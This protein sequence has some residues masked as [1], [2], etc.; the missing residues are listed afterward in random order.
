[1]PPT[2]D[3][4]GAAVV[5]RGYDA[6]AEA[7]ISRHNQRMSRLEQAG[8]YAQSTA[9]PS[10][11]GA[12]PMQALLLSLGASRTRP[13]SFSGRTWPDHLAWAVDSASAAVRMLL[14]WQPVGAAVLART[15]LERWSSNVEFNSDAI[16]GPAEDNVAWLSRLWHQ[17]YGD[18][19]GSVRPAGTL[20]AEL[21]EVL[22]GRGPLMPLVW[23]DVADVTRVPGCDEFRLVDVV[24]DAFVLTLNQVRTCIETVARERGLDGLRAAA[25]VIPVAGRAEA[26]MTSVM[27]STVPLL[28][29]HLGQLFGVLADAESAYDDTVS[30]IVAGRV[31]AVP[32][33]VAPALVFGDHRYRALVTA[34]TAFERERGLLGPKF[35]E[36]GIEDTSTEAVLAGEMAGV[37]AIWLRDEGRRHAA[38]AFATASSALR[39]ATWLWLED[40]DRAMGCL[41]CVIEQL[42]RVRVWRLKPDRA[43]R[44]ENNP[45]TSPR[46]W[47][48]RSG[49]QRLNVLSRALG[50][51][52]HGSTSTNPTGARELLIALQKDTESSEARYTGRTHALTALVF[53]TSVECA[54][55]VRLFDDELAQAYRKVIRVTQDAGEAVV[56]GLLARSHEQAAAQFR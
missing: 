13:P 21:S 1:M 54:E 23:L 41:R 10:L 46:D 2:V 56:E 53:M 43:E 15:Q 19:I 35:V 47:L 24:T 14:A 37:L 4:L 11:M 38:D 8:S 48:S 36:F 3:G 9:L 6:L 31:P 39:S 44:M 16:R 45:R 28:P 52:V 7:L 26:S 27:V 50:E 22:H 40:D 55:W 32:A 42:A 20:F 49:W 5:A 25:R 33:D 30:A 29:S 18:S 34:R 12:A 17:A 51:F